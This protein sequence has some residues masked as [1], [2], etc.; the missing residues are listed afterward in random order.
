[1]NENKRNSIVGLLLFFI[2]IVGDIVSGAIGIASPIQSCNSPPTLIQCDDASITMPAGFGTVLERINFTRP[3]C[4]SCG[5]FSSIPTV[6][7]TPGDH[8]GFSN[9]V[10]EMYPILAS[11]PYP[12]P[13]TNIP[14]TSDAELLNSTGYRATIYR[15]GVGPADKISMQFQL[16]T[17]TLISSGTFLQIQYSLNFGSTWNNLTSTTVTIG[18][19]TT[20]GW[21]IGPEQTVPLTMTGSSGTDMLRIV[22][23][24]GGGPGDQANF[25]N[26]N[27]LIERQLFSNCTIYVQTT[28]RT[29]AFFTIE[30]DCPVSI[31]SFTGHLTWRARL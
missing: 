30:M 4:P 16:N 26:I 9:T 7:L 20:L 6:L 18:V 31:S 21:K 12:T 22:A 23:E 11:S 5:P 8:L 24:N 3:T 1:M 13:W 28:L 2:I 19:G 27:I 17:T 10:E 14:S 29:A 25:G 15:N